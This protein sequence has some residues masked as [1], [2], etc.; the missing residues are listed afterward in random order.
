MIG[1]L[2]SIVFVWHSTK[3]RLESLLTLSNKK[4]KNAEYAAQ[5]LLTVQFDTLQPGVCVLVFFPSRI[6]ADSILS[7]SL[8]NSSDWPAVLCQR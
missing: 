6:L 1:I 2:N 5:I 3:G 8:I 4:I 7:S